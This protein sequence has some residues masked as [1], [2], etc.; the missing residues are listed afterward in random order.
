MSLSVE[1]G[2]VYRSELEEPGALGSWCERVHE[3]KQ[4]VPWGRVTRTLLF[5]DDYP[6]AYTPGEKERVAYQLTHAAASQSVR[7]DAVAFESSCAA[8]ADELAANLELHHDDAL[9]P[10]VQKYGDGHF[11]ATALQKNGYWSCPALSAVWLLARLGE[12]PY[13]SLVKDEVIGLEEYAAHKVLTVLPTR[14]I[15]TEA[16]VVEILRQLRT[17]RVSLKRVQYVLT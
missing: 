1:L 17:P 8:A 11:H 3:E 16:A 13:H 14:Y 12:E 4:L 5:V 9:R 10:W 2:H 15:D 7:V 6:E